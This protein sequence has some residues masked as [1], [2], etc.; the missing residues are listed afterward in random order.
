MLGWK[1]NSETCEK[2]RVHKIKYSLER[3]LKKTIKTKI[4]ENVKIKYILD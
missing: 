2:L 3:K 1:S 4:K